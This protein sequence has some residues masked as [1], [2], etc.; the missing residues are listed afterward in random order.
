MKKLAF[1]VLLAFTNLL[2]SQETAFTPNTGDTEMDGFLHQINND[3][4]KDAGAFTNM[5]TNKFNIAKTDVEKLLKD[6]VPGDVYMAAQVASIV[7]KPVTQVSSTYLK[8][9]GKGWGAIAKEMGIKPGSPEFHAL[10]KSM[11]KPGGG[12]DEGEGNGKGN[13]NGHGNGHGHGKK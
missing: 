9:K 5:I 4:K 3:A 11:K 8:N 2:W 7:N 13:G 10:K 1:I 12:N 6:M